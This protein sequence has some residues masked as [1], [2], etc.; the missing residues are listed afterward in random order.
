MSTCRN[1]L[2][3]AAFA[4]AALA[5]SSTYAQTTRP[6][7][8]QMIERGRYIAKIAGCNDCHTPG[9]PQSGGKVPEKDWLVGDVVGWKGDWGTTYPANLR[10][11][12]NTMNE[13]QWVEYARKLET[14]P[15][16]PWFALHDLTEQDL[17]S[18]HRFVRSLGPAGSPAPAYVSPG[19]TPKGPYIQFPGAPQNAAL[20]ST[21]SAR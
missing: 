7:D 5:V 14:R 1:I 19:A 13:N 11:V 8:A 12:L 4:L 17:R 2:L 9:Y 15:P 18:F 10:L 16:M 6:T 3:G 20:P 21:V